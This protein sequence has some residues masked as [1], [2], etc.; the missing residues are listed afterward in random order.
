MAETYQSIR[1]AKLGDFDTVSLD[2]VELQPLKEGEVLVRMECS[3]I[4]PSDFHIAKGYYGAQAVPMAMGFEGSGTVVKSGGGDLADSYVNKRVAV[5]NSGTWAE[6]NISPVNSVF[7]LHEGTTFEQGASL[8]VNPFLI[9]GFIEIIQ[10]KHHRA[11]VINAASSALGKMFVKWGVKTNFPVIALVRKQ[12]HVD[13]L[14]ALGAQH[15]FNTS[16]EGWKAQARLVSESVGA[17]IGFDCI[18][19]GATNDMAEILLDK[20]TIYNFGYF[21]G[22]PC[23]FSGGQLIAQGKKLKGL[24]MT[25]YLFAKDLEG[26][27]KVNDL[28]QELRADV[29]AAE[30]S[31]E[32]GLTGVRQAMDEYAQ[33]TTNNKILIKIRN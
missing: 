25:T 22:E 13:F 33:V 15:V 14:K 2:T 24:S 26:R 17:T 16:E 3:T 9:A 28:V 10:K 6:Y 31:K 21:S 4:N 18:A 20:G 27:L 32:V 8:I 11:A 5:L 19:G 29:F 1:I 12:E 7:P 30:Y 23:H